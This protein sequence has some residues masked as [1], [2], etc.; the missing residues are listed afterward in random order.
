MVGIEVVVALPILG[1]IDEVLRRPRIKRKYRV[2][3][4]EIAEYLRL[5]SARATLVH[6]SG[7]TALCRDPDDDVLLEAAI[8]GG[9]DYLVTR[10][11]DIKRDLDLMRHMKERG[12]EVVSVSQFLANL[13]TG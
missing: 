13:G 3:D 5:I 1:E 8:A 9:V 10:D 11:D 7:K 4:S 6:I 12:V 2:R